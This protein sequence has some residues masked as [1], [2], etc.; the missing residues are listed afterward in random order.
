MHQIEAQVMG[1]TLLGVLDGE[2]P[3]IVAALARLPDWFRAW[4]RCLSRFDPASELRRLNA[5]AGVPVAVGPV[6]W[7]AL[8]DALAA[9]RW[10]AGLV[11]PTVLAAVEHAGY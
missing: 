4:E 6:L 11:T 5:R 10:T 7:D 2:G 3:E 1:S 8:R 9:A